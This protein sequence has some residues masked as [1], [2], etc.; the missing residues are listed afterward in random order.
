MISAFKREID[1]TADLVALPD[2]DLARDQLR[3]AQR[4]ERFEQFVDRP[5]RLVD[6]VDEDEMRDALLVE[7]A[8]RRGGERRARRV[9]I[10]HHDARSA[11]A[12]A[13]AAS[14]AKPI[15][16]G[17]SMIANSPPR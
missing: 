11:T 6:A 5:M 8:Q 15:E 14:A 12:I 16:P 3:H 7:H 1:E 17:A 2:R 9:G 10:D 4:L 13:R